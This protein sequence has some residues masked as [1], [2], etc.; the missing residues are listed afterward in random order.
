MFGLE[1]LLRR[2]AQKQETIEGV[3][4][5]QEKEKKENIQDKESSSTSIREKLST[6]LKVVTVVILLMLI[7]TAVLSIE[8]QKKQNLHFSSTVP[9][10]MKKKE[11]NSQKS[12]FVSDSSINKVEKNIRRTDTNI[13]NIRK[14][15]E[16][17]DVSENNLLAELTEIK[18]NLYYLKA[19]NKLLDEKI[20]NLEKKKKIS[21]L[22]KGLTQQKIE[23]APPNYVDNLT[24]QLQL[25]ERKIENL[26]KNKKDSSIKS[27][28]KKKIEELRA[29]FM[30]PKS[31]Q[32]TTHSYT[33]VAIVGNEAVIKRDGKEMTVKDGELIDGKRVK[34]GSFSVYIGNEELSLSFTDKS[35][36]ISSLPI[37]FRGSK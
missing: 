18:R 36:P 3:K 35:S 32:S 12:S 26:A 19:E 4:V 21:E 37:P 30:K 14:T 11:R 33:L 20:K 15:Q 25:L 9:K 31:S 34:V 29:P 2:N 23:I 13:S 24:K 1:K 28:I 7:G 8:K 6:P 17:A 5:E 16:T 22:Q 27:E 10:P